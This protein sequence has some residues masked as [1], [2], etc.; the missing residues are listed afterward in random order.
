MIKLSDGQF[1]NASLG[2]PFF[3]LLFHSTVLFFNLPVLVFVCVCVLITEGEI[4]ISTLSQSFV[5]LHPFE[6][7]SLRFGFLT[8]TI[9]SHPLCPTFCAIN[10]SSKSSSD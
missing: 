4:A 3:S 7:Y 9:T 5:H 6:L 1:S 10:G 8:Q 2:I